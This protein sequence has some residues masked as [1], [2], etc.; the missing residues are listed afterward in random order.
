MYIKDFKAISLFFKVMVLGTDTGTMEIIS[1]YFVHKT[2]LCEDPKYSIPFSSY[3][4]KPN[5]QNLMWDY[6]TQNKVV[7]S[8][9]VSVFQ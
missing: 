9:K 3:S 6:L 4:W 1:T 8:Q 5:K 7:K 2:N